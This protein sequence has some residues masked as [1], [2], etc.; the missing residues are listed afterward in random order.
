MRPCFSKLNTVRRMYSPSEKSTSQVTSSSSSVIATAAISPVEAM[1]HEP[2][3]SL[4]PSSWP[5][6]ADAI[7]QHAFW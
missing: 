5:A 6:L 3:M 1:M 7:T 2:P 4:N